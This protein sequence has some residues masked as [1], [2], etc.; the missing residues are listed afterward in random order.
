MHKFVDTKGDEWPVE[1]TYGEI[2]KVKNELG[3][4]LVELFDDNATALADIA[5]SPELIVSVTF[6]LV[7][8]YADAKGI[9][10]E[11]FAYRM[12]GDVLLA[13]LDAIVKATID[14]FPNPRRRESLAG[15]YSRLQEAGNKAIESMTPVILR[16][17]DKAMEK[18][19]AT[20]SNA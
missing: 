4:N 8:K 18:H 2:A 5:D 10:P 19:L 16:G 14:F 3:I 12:G 9:G 6:C 15:I 20:L 1:V 11:D 7:E 13:A 17:I